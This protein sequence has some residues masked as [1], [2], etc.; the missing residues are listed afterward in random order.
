M[1]GGDMTMKRTTAALAAFAVAVAVALAMWP[2]TGD[3][4]KYGGYLKLGSMSI[5]ESGAWWLAMPGQPEAA[6]DQ[7]S[8]V[9]VMPEKDAYGKPRPIVYT[10]GDDSGNLFRAVLGDA[11]L[12][13]FT[14]MQVPPWREGMDLED[15]T[16]IAETGEFAVSLETGDTRVRVVREA[17]GGL[18]TRYSFDLRLP[19]RY[20]KGSNVGPEGLA[21]D[22]DAGVLIVGWEGST[23][24]SY[25]SFYRLTID[26][27]RV[28]HAEFLRHLDVNDGPTSI[29][30]LFYDAE[31]RT[32]LAL[33][34]DS[35]ALYIYPQWDTEAVLESEGEKYAGA[36]PLIARFHDIED[37]FH[38]Q[39]YHYSF[40]GV[41]V[42]D[43]GTLWVVTD[44]WRSADKS[45]YRLADG[46]IDAYYDK[47]VSQLFAFEGF[48]DAVHAQ[49]GTGSDAASSG[50]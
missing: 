50:G 33:D 39:F 16:Y 34:R 24:R 19:P 3:A 11:C 13:R 2:V 1:S 14:G 41:H 38:R 15:L 20:E 45:K 12:Q 32:L 23:L 37:A 9:W 8:G 36:K 22:G 21:W 5:A 25:L 30:G 27:G 18:E 49:L 7:V 26:E 42:D 46:T 31:T 10:V 47:F 29:C 6:Q 28:T 48:R 17:D 35:D 43:A 4:A 44:P 40:E